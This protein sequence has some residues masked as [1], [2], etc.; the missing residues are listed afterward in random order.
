MAALPFILHPPSS[1][2]V[3]WWGAGSPVWAAKPEATHLQLS[4]R[5]AW[6]ESKLLPRNAQRRPVTGTG[7]LGPVLLSCL[8]VD[9]ILEV[10]E[11]PQGDGGQSPCA[12]LTRAHISPGTDGFCGLGSRPPFSEA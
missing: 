5:R 2:V 7:R 6:A 12:G 10:Q 3:E 8:T 1:S 4:C 9:L 11:Q